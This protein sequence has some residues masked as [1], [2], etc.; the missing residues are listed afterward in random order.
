MTPSDDKIHQLP[1]TQI[2]WFRHYQEFAEKIL[3][4]ALNSNILLETGRNPTEY[5]LLRLSS[6]PPLPFFFFFTSS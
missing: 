5:I 3:L 1:W 6:L 2:M 4:L